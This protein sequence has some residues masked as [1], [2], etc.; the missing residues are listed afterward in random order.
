[1]TGAGAADLAGADLAGPDVASPAVADTSPPGPAPADPAP[2]DTAAGTAGA[3]GAGGG[4]GG[5]SGAGFGANRCTGRL[6]P[7]S[8]IGRSDGRSS[9][10][11]IGRSM[12]ARSTAAGRDRLAKYSRSRAT[13]SSARLA[14]ADPLP[15]IPALAQI[16][17]NSLLSYFSSFANEYIR[18]AKTGSPSLFRF[19]LESQASDE[20]PR[21]F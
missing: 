13:S 21:I 10:R 19:A 6:D 9:G 14:S 16:S 2:A 11:S 12:G 3:T 5:A 17:T 4:G 15:V 8:R 18:T 7:R 1:M 20:R